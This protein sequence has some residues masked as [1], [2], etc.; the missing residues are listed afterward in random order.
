MVADRL[1]LEE[2]LFE[3]QLE[4]LVDRDEQQLIVRGGI[5]FELLQLQDLGDLQVGA[6]GED[7]VF[8]S[9]TRRSALE[10]Q[11]RT[12]VLSGAALRPT[13]SSFLPDLPLRSVPAASV[14]ASSELE[15]GAASPLFSATGVGSGADAYI[16][17]SG[18]AM[19]ETIG[20]PTS[21]RS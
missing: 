1:E 4:D 6:V 19:T 12:R 2:D 8:L 16:G 14:S 7:P 9:E 17:L 15:V 10:G 13:Q 11:L 21:T 20:V 18:P 5:R 3:P